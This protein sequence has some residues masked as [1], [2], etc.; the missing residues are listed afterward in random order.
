MRGG[1]VESQDETFAKGFNSVSF[2][3]SS[4]SDEYDFRDLFAR[5]TDATLGRQHA[6]SS[7]IGRCI[8]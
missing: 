3:A 6:L 8:F 4:A 7:S 1:A 5:D 2:D